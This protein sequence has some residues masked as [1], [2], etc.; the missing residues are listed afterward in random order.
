M[1]YIE[2][3]PFMDRENPFESM[4]SRFKIA[5]EILGLDE[6]VYNVLKSPAKQVSVSLPITM[7]DGSYE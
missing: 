3:A 2:P 4:M 6:E 5:S 1:A 7:D